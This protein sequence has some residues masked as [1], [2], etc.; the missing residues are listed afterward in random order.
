ME[1][2]QSMEIERPDIRKELRRQLF[3]HFLRSGFK[4]EDDLH[5]YIRE[6]LGFNIPRKKFCEGHCAP[7]DIICDMFFERVQN[8]LILGNRTG[9]K[10]RII[11]ILNHLDALFIEENEIASCGSTLDQAGKVYRYFMEYS[12]KEVIIKEQVE[13]SI[14]SYSKMRN[15]SIVETLTGTI[16]GVN[17]PHPMKARID[18]VELMEWQVLNEAFSMSMSKVN[19]NGKEIKGQLLLASTRKYGHG[20]MQRLMDESEKRRIKIYNWCVFEVLEKC[21]RKCFGDRIH[22]DC[23]AYSACKGRAHEVPGG[24]Y[25][26]DDFISKTTQLDSDV[27]AAQWF[28][29]SPSEEKRVYAKIDPEAHFITLK[30][31]EEIFGEKDV[32]YHWEIRAGLDLGS[33]TAFHQIGIEP[34]TKSYVIF[35]EIYEI[36]IL[37]KDLSEKIK[38]TRNYSDSEPIYRDPSAKQEGLELETYGIRTILANNS[39]TV[40]RDRIKNLIQIDPKIGRPRFFIIKERC[41]KLCWEILDY[42]HVKNKD[43]TVDSTRPIKANDHACDDIRYGIMGDDE[44]NSVEQ[45]AIETGTQDRISMQNSDEI[46]DSE[47]MPAER[48]EMQHIEI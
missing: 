23:P 29:K 27:L 40:G 6:F 43:G 46:D 16:Q 48:E 15:G 21:K 41:P 37:L 5:F 32:P 25:K 45:G 39:F 9:G 47:F 12:N 8:A 33:I 4:D 38:K 44:M 19:S 36:D 2:A 28:N 34:D 30:Q 13:K 35:D 11:S 26:I 24:W 22:G 10:T 3:N 31:F 1:Y 14:Q 42:S 17:S 7:F 20:V 18:E